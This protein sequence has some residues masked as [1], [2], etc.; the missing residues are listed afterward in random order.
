MQEIKIEK[1]QFELLRKDF[2]ALKNLLALNAKQ[3]KAQNV[4]VA[5]AMGVSP[6]R[7]SQLIPTKKYKKRKKESKK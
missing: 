5:K 6:G 4:D 3:L 2:E 7:A 1:K